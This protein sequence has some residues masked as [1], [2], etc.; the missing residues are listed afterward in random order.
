MAT[1]NKAKAPSKLCVR[2]NQVLPIGKFY[3]NKGWAQQS[4]RDA[5]CMECAGKYCK[6]KETIAQYCYENNR[7]WD[8]SFWTSALKKA[9]YVLAT[10]PDYISPKTSDE[11]RQA[12]LDATAAKQF[13]S[14]MNM[15][16]FYFFVDN[17]ADNGKKGGEDETI[18]YNR[19]WRGHFSVEQVEALE[20]IY[21]QY[22]EDFV[23]DNVNIRDYARKVAKASLNADI[24]EDKMRRG[25]ISA[26]EYKEAQKIFDDLSK[27]SNFA[28]CRR[29]PG[30][31]SGMGS[32]GE[33]IL[34]LEVSGELNIEGVTFPPDDVDKIIEDF[35]HTLKAVGVEDR[36]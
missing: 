23:L 14:M 18:P 12:L 33:I 22:E 25:Q 34:K 8:P 5:W 10:N 27:S 17:M 1:N 19:K 32:L 35:R 4:Y 6:D 7:R 9:Q 16:T 21:A 11:N 13:F 36:L 26:S 15:A 20:E 2:C 29:K 28:A 24:A 3:S 31:T 30:D